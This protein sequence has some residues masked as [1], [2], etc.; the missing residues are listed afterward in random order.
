[1]KSRST[2]EIVRRVSAYL[3]PYWPMAVGTVGCAI[4][5]LAFAFVYPKLTQ[6]ILD[7]VI[8]EN[9]QDLLAPAVGALLGA[10]LLREGFNSLRI[11]I[12]NTFEQNVIFDMRRAVF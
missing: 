6:F 11:W 8:G 10:F 1:A 9:R 2:W 4:A 3:R 7:R 12:N 5:S